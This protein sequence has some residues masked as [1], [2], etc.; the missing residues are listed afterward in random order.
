MLM[1]WDVINTLLGS[2]VGKCYLEI[3]VQAGGCG[4]NIKAQ[5]RWGVD[6]EP[7]AGAERQYH[8]FFRGTSDA[9]F[10]SLAAGQQFDVVF[11]DGLHHAEQVLRDAENALN[12]LAPGGAVV[13][14]DCNPHSEI[15]QRVPR[16]QEEWTGDCWKAL[17]ALRQRPDVDAF[18]VNADYGIGVVRPKVGATPL[19]LSTPELTY[20]ELER[21]RKRLLGLTAPE[22]WIERLG[23]PYALGKVVVVS[24]IFGHKDRPQRAP[25]KSDV[26]KFVMF[27]DWMAHSSWVR[28]NVLTG[29]E[30]R[31]VA[32]KYKT[33]ALD[34]VEADVVVWIDGRVRFSGEP[35]RPLLTRTL[36]DTDIAGYPHPDRM[37]VFEEASVC[38]RLGLGSTDRLTQQVADYKAEGFEDAGGLWATGVL[39]RRN[40]EAMR[41]FGRAWWQQLQKYTMRD[42]ISF[43]YLLWKH[44]L[45]CAPLGQSFCKPGSSKHFVLGEHRRQA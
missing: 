26:D 23:P 32:R 45:R 44:G 6:P 33:L 11:I 1:R 31:A 3:G 14:H 7:V 2:P 16:A 30:P 37:S 5:E 39:V 29:D 43:P 18:V 38:S 42:Q 4:A 17:V 22:R 15:M 10:E 21:D 13:L 36:R 35:L 8:R 24:A 19:Q 41:E 25:T 9:F 12:R 20:A 40:T 28:K 34:Y 27:T